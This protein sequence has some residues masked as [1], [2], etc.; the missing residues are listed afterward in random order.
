MPVIGLPMPS[1]R[2]AMSV[3]QSLTTDVIFTRTGHFS[4]TGISRHSPPAERQQ[5]GCGCLPPPRGRGG[6]VLAR[7][8][9]TCWTL[10]TSAPDPKRTFRGYA[11][12]LAEA[13]PPGHDSTC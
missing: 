10:R 9:P 5:T 6:P 2:S 1:T 11:P 7:S 4:R 12:G 13:R 8:A 3:R